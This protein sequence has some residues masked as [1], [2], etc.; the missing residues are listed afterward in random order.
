MTHSRFYDSILTELQAGNVQ[1]GVTLLVG[2]LDSER[3]E[4][5]AADSASVELKAHDLWQLL[6]HEPLCAQAATDPNDS[7]ALGDILCHGA[8][9]SATSSTG[10][11][12]FAVTR[13]LTFSRAF[14]ERR[15]QASEILIRAWQAG[16][17][18]CLPG[19]SD[20]G[21][22]AALAGHDLSNVTVADVNSD[23]LA[24]LKSQFGL[25]IQIVNEEALSFL[26]RAS[27]EG[28][29]FDL[30]CATELLDELES[31]GLAAALPVMAGALSPSGKILTASLLPGHLGSGWR[32]TC[33]G[34][35]LHCH[36]E[37]AIER[38]SNAA[39]LTVRTYRDATD[40]VV[41]AEHKINSATPKGGEAHGY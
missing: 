4:A 2:M 25:S 9:P 15:R 27:S 41:W 3:G 1:D 37:L 6:Q 28:K 26:E 39:G 23:C 40:C 30:I 38:Y 34:W 14:R 7:H 19:C 36:D 17:R 31:A 11:R 5:F 35:N 20:F 29:R 32:R 33:L 18:I 13:E 8:S 12:L 24:R 10:Q 16:Q 22:L 21:A